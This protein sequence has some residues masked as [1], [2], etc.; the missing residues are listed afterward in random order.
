MSFQQLKRDE[1][2]DVADFF[3]VDVEMANPEK[4]ATK[5]ELIAALASGDE[6]VTWSDYTETYLP[7]QGTAKEEEQPVD[8]AKD[9]PVKSEPEEEENLVL[10]KY[11]RKNP[12]FEVGPYLFST[13]HPYKSVP[14]DVAQALVQDAGGF[15]LALPK[16]VT[17]YYS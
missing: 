9:E 5:K 8:D 14:E 15:R 3:V 11:E 16:E 13:A 7:A 12:T 2:Q 17:D 4:G 6:P 10:V 1:L